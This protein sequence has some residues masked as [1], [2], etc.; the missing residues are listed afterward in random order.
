[1]GCSS[2]S[3]SSASSSSAAGELL[4]SSVATVSRKLPSFLFLVR[5]GFQ[6]GVDPPFAVVRHADAKA[7][8]R[9]AKAAA[10]K[11]SDLN[12]V[13]L[14]LP[15]NLVGF[16]KSKDRELREVASPTHDESWDHLEQLDLFIANVEAHPCDLRASV[17]KKRQKWQLTL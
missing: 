7:A 10:D 3:Q 15:S 8:N 1:M 13:V 5:R 4:L 2:S 6:G 14:N 11:I 16:Y 9:K 17:N 12:E